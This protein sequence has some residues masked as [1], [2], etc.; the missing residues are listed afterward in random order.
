MTTVLFVLQEGNKKIVEEKKKIKKIMVFVLFLFFGQTDF[1][2]EKS[3]RLLG[4][5]T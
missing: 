1:I 4:I 5:C 3:E 2:S